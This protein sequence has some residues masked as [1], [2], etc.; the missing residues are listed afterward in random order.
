MG[1]SRARWRFRCSFLGCS[2]VPRW[3]SACRWPPGCPG[4]LQRLC[5]PS[6]W[7]SPWPWT[8]ST[9]RP[10]ERQGPCEA[11][12]GLSCCRTSRSPST[13]E[14]GRRRT[15]SRRCCSGGRAA[16]QQ[17][18]GPPLGR[19]WPWAERGATRE[20]ASVFSDDRRADP[21]VVGGQP[22]RWTNNTVLSPWK[23]LTWGRAGPNPH[24]Y[25]WKA[26]GSA[27]ST[28]R[29]IPPVGT[30]Q[31]DRRSAREVRRA[32]GSAAPGAGTPAS[33]LAP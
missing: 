23:C 6:L 28:N 24:R 29:R 17:H 30:V 2:R 10:W 18:N 8:S 22:G 1:W 32:R 27:S 3:R 9:R 11:R 20:L 7:S 14:S 13:W 12:R 21:Q 26:T 16:S 19:R 15:I 33:G 25:R 31:R 5:W 4:A